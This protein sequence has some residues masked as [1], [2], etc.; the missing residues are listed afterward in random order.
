MDDLI[1]DIPNDSKYLEYEDFLVH[2]Y[3]GEHTNFPLNILSKFVSDLTRIT[4]N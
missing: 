4:N 1:L 2:N 3:I